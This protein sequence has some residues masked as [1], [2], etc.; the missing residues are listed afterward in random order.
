MDR[1][2]IMRLFVRIVERASLSAAGQDLNIPRASVTRAVQQLE[3][4]LGVRLLERNTRAVRATADGMLYYAR[5]TQLLAA[6]EATESLFRVSEPSGPVCVDMQGTL[7]RFFVM[8]S[9]PDF[10]ARYPDITLR[11]SEGD[12]MVDLIA[13]GVDCVLRAGIL[14]DSSL[15]GRQIA[16]SEQVTL[17]SPAYLERHGSPQTLDDLSAHRMVGYTA[18]A[19]GQPYSLDFMVDGRRREVDL[20]Y[21]LTLRGAELYTAAGLAG[22]GLIQV[23]RYRVAHQIKSGEL[24]VILDQFQPAP[25]PVSVLFPDNR[26]MAPRVRVFVDWL[27]KVFQD[28]K[29]RQELERLWEGH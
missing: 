6:F 18:S 4:R 11:L 3:T 14:P 2:E 7:A 28:A 17:A 9:L 10:L 24:V 8:P 29:S 20:P 19:N 16:E 21:D 26:N 13:E 22:F 25:M 12:R 1:F 15:V 5:C 27:A 23:P